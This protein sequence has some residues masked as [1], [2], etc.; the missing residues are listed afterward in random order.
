MKH[1]H[2][3]CLTFNFISTSNP[4]LPFT[5]PQSLFFK[6]SYSR[7][8]KASNQFPASRFKKSL[9]TQSKKS[10]GMFTIACLL[11]TMHP[12]NRNQAR[13][14]CLRLRLEARAFQFIHSFP[15]LSEMLCKFVCKTKR[16]PKRRFYCRLRHSQR[17]SHFH[18]SFFRRLHSVGL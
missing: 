8:V 15:V 5:P 4:V 13:F 9:R 17:C 18:W 10:G 3:F 1:F 7:L 14:L 11:I 6:P 16:P 12:K 2:P